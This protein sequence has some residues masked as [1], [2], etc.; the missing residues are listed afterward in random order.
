MRAGWPASSAAGGAVSGRRE[1]EAALNVL[2]GVRVNVRGYGV[3][4]IR[5]VVE[6]DG[7]DDAQVQHRLDQARSLLGLA[8]LD[9]RAPARVGKRPARERRWGSKHTI[10]R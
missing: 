4:P 8:P 1:R 7:R 5:V 3:D 9:L 10:E 6:V 2:V